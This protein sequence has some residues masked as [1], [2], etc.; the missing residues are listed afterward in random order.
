MAAISA[1]YR[2]TVKSWENDADNYQTI[3]LD[4]YTFMQTQFICE[5]L[6]H[7][8]SH[9]RGAQQF[10]NLYE[11]D[12]D[13]KAETLAFWRELYAKH[14][15]AAKELDIPPPNDTNDDDDEGLEDLFYTFCEFVQDFIG[16]SEHYSTRVAE[17]VVVEYVPR[18]IILED[19]TDQFVNKKG[20]FSTPDLVDVGGILQLRTSL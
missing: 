7:M 6:S 14:D 9:N 5:L 12:D 16:T 4:G 8:G 2:I 13:E 15:V 3:I 1:G 11:P 19:V 18:D 10:G 17:S 20:S